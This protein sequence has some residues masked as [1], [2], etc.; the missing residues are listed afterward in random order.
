MKMLEPA[1]G[2]DLGTTNC[3]VAYI[4]EKG[5]PEIIKNS[6]GNNTTPSVVLFP[7]Q[8]ETIV[9]VEAKQQIAFE[10]ENASSFFKRDMGTDTSYPFQNKYYTPA[11]LSA[12]LLK[13]LKNDAEDAL[14]I[15]INKAVITVP[16]YFQDK[17]RVNTKEAA[18]LAGLE[19]L[20]I[21]NE[22]TAAALAYGYGKSDNEEIVLVY[23]LGGGTFDVSLVI[24]SS[25]SIKVIGTD[26][27]H[28]L[29][30][31]DW[32]DRLIDYFATEFM[33]KHGDDQDPRDDSY[34]MQ[35]L[36]NKTEDAKKSL[37][38]RKNVFLHINYFGKNDRIEI[39]R[40]KFE[41]LTKD[42]LSQ[43]E[44][45]IQKVLDETNYTFNQIS[46]ILMVGGSTR[47][48]MCR[49]LVEKISGKKP[50]CTLNP[51][52]CVALGAA[53]QADLEL[54][55]EAD[56]IPA[57]LIKLQDVTAHSLGLVVISADGKKYEN[58]IIL[59]KNRPIPAD[60]SHTK[61]LRTSPRK[62][63]Q[64]EVYLLQGESKRPMDNTLLGKYTFNEIPHYDG[65]TRIKIGFKYDSN[66]IVNV[67]AYDEKSGRKI[68]GPIIDNKNIDISWTDNEPKITKDLEEI[69]IMLC[70]DT[71]GSM[72]GEKLRQAKAGALNFMKNL[73]FEYTSVGL[74]SFDNEARLRMYFTKS[75]ED[76][77]N[78]LNSLHIGG[79]T[80]M[81][82]ALELACSNLLDNDGRHVIVLL[83]DGY[84][85]NISSTL[86]KV[87][88]CKE[89]KIEIIAIGTDGA[90]QKFLK[91]LATSQEGQF[92]A[93]VKDIG[94]V[95]SKIA[96]DLSEHKGSLKFDN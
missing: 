96:Q 32:E 82:H 80:N 33:K 1:I 60:D 14:G 79:S 2:I 78:G 44:T 58:A 88:F 17:A 67:E 37:S 75:L 95:F 15:T 69:Y 84:P 23:D 50:N 22:P 12:E 71:S 59:P 18:E 49:D 16:A 81:T 65:E 62:E 19:V 27:N 48:L 92:F 76:M 7:S 54:H 36:R 57:G 43:T 66:G 11:E 93:S 73:D 25:E 83:T 20:N 64:L 30:G 24:I 52:E 21:I 8:E 86:N 89:K 53:I 91:R 77:Q 90:D 34:I 26:G 72:N 13:K 42:L 87:Q 4:N 31:K 85:N 46:N 35:D 9:G 47:M 70:I 29:G 3:A 6:Y 56:I 38:S 40:Q 45:L 10:V 68:N 61:V 41:N 5:K 51:D 94:T 39:T 55:R 63:N 28:N 74:L